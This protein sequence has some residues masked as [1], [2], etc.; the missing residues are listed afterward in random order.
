VDGALEGALEAVEGACLVA[1]HTCLKRLRVSYI[2]YNSDTTF[3]VP[4]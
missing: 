4:L 1:G 2:T 3:D